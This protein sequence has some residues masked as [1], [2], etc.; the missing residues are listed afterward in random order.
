MSTQTLL[1]TVDIGNTALKVSVFSGETLLKSMA[2]KN[3]FTDNLRRMLDS[4]PDIAGVVCCRVG[5][6][7][8]GVAD[9]LR[10]M[11]PDSYMEIG[12]DTPV[13]LSVNYNRGTLGNDRL[14]AAVGVAAP[15]VSVL[16]VDAGTAVTLDMTRGLRYEGGNISP[17]LH[18]RFEALHRFT[19]HLP[20]VEAEGSAPFLGN[21][22]DSAIRSGVEWGLAY[23]VAETFARARE[24]DDNILL[25]LT[26]GN[27]RL[28]SR[29]LTILNIP[30][31]IDCEAVGRGLVRIFNF[32]NKNKV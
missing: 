20:M 5:A 9:M 28:L 7:R 6:D 15:G 26:G 3:G 13:P 21:S 23:E 10:G 27:A 31:D 30:H 11:Y 25:V 17:G 12:P 14:A 2:C 24:L 16:L 32:K 4:Y 19:Q 1:L 8:L 22:T 29:Y 18:L